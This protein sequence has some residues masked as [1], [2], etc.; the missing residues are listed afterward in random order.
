MLFKYFA[1]LAFDFSRHT[2]N[3]SVHNN[4]LGH[5]LTKTVMTIL[6]QHE[7]I[8]TYTAIIAWDVET[9]MDTTSIELVITFINIWRIMQK[10]A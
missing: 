6:S 4:F 5:I 8:V 7:A 3:M 9:F 1:E 2:I 10:L